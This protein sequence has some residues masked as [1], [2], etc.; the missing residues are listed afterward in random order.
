[1]E[2]LLLLEDIKDTMSDT[3]CKQSYQIRVILFCLHF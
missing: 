1:M 2:L 3:E